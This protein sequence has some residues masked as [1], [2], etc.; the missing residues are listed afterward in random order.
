MDGIIALYATIVTVILFFQ[1][2]EINNWMSEMIALK[3]ERDRR[4]AELDT[5]K[6]EAQDFVAKATIVR[7]RYP[8]AMAWIY[9]GI[10]AVLIVTAMWELIPE[11]HA[12]HLWQAELPFAVLFLV[13]VIIWPAY[14][15][16]QRK[17]LGGIITDLRRKHSL[18]LEV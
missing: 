16:G 4:R 12:K 10:Q 17:A 7:S 13:V 11:E 8:S 6:R 3:N 9:T 15:I 2:I 5:T 18:E 14:W 1:G